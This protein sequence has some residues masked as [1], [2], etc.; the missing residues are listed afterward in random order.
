VKYDHPYRREISDGQVLHEEVQCYRQLDNQIR[1]QEHVGFA[2]PL[3]TYLVPRMA[4]I[5]DR[6]CPGNF[7]SL[8]TRASGWSMGPSDSKTFLPHS[9]PHGHRFYREV[10]RWAAER[11]WFRLALFRLDG[12]TIA[13]DLCLEASD[14]PR[15][16]Q[17]RLRSRLQNAKRWNDLE[18]D[19]VEWAF[20]GSTDTY[21]FL[22]TIVPAKNRG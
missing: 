14:G 22:A 12:R 17:D 7:R 19:D 21:E 13:L 18:V 20:A 9:N 3:A 11:G 16:D 10:A 5:Q 2:A 1:P 4:P 8:A 6:K 15:L